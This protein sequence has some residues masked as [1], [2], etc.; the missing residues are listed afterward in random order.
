MNFTTEEVLLLLVKT[1]YLVAATL[2]L[3]GLQRMAPIRTMPWMKLL[4]DISG[5]CRITGT[6]EMMTCPAMAAS[7]KM[8]IIIKAWVTEPSAIVVLLKS[9]R[10]I[11]AASGQTI[12]R[13]GPQPGVSPSMKAISGL[14]H[15]AGAS[16]YGFR[17][18][19]VNRSAARAFPSLQ[20]C[21]RSSHFA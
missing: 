8:Y 10:I 12:G 9:D 16:A 15:R 19:A 20:A 18:N 5:V 7:M 17:R 2:F 14:R 13:W 11:T 1:S 3:L 6:R 4:P 21:R